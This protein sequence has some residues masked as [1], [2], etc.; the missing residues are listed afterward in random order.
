MSCNWVVHHKL[1]SKKH[2]VRKSV[3]ARVPR[4]SFARVRKVLVSHIMEDDGEPQENE[5]EDE[6][7]DGKQREER[8]AVESIKTTTS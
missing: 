6:R 1:S 4:F 3:S 7:E 8:R 2:V 5:K